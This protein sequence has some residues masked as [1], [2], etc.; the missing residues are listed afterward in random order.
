MIK[1][2][3]QA[4]W[5]SQAGKSPCLVL[6]EAPCSI[7]SAIPLPF[8][9]Q[10][11]ENLLMFFCKICVQSKKKKK[12]AEC[13]VGMDETWGIK[14]RNPALQKPGRSKEGISKT[15]G[16]CFFFT[17]VF[18]VWLK[19]VYLSFNGITV[20]FQTTKCIF[21]DSWNSPKL[22]ATNSNTQPAQTTQHSPVL[23]HLFC[24][25]TWQHFVH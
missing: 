9:G 13:W 7:C 3:N 22:K 15:K 10:C 1:Y 16:F 11:L 2:G 20:G 17:F 6:T 23:K 14:Q 12:V 24:S 8:P 19:L 21:P 4:C 25:H 18:S 5:P